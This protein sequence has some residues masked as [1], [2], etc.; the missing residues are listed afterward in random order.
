VKKWWI[1]FAA[2]LI[3]ASLWGLWPKPQR[4]RIVSHDPSFVIYDFQY[5]AQTN[6][7]Y[8][9][10][11]AWRDALGFIGFMK[12]RAFSCGPALVIYHSVPRNRSGVLMAPSD[13]VFFTP[14]GMPCSESCE[15]FGSN[16]CVTK[17]FCELTN[18]QYQLS[19][20]ASP[21][22]NFMDIYVTK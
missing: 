14:S 19:K 16:K 21:W 2:L 12:V 17:F 20:A 4:I 6:R 13:L 22:T 15:Y 1:G 7:I 9:W 5:Y 10:R 18:G 3:I 11:A 8:Y